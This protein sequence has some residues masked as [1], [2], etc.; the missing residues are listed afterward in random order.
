MPKSQRH[1]VPKIVGLE[2]QVCKLW[3]SFKKVILNK[4]PEYAMLT[5]RTT[6]FGMVRGSDSCSQLSAAT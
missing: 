2:I 4:T 6:N 1:Q 5:C 3:P